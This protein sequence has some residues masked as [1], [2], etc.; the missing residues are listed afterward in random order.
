MNTPASTSQQV[1]EF[2]EADYTNHSNATIMIEFVEGV[3]RAYPLKPGERMD[4]SWIKA[5]EI[6]GVEVA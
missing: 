5:F 6:K 3:S 1:Q 4:T 2:I